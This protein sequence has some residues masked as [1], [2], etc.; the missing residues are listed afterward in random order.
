MRNELEIGIQQCECRSTQD[1]TSGVNTILP[2]CLT[3]AG[4]RPW[5]TNQCNIISEG[6][7]GSLGT[8]ESVARTSTTGTVCVNCILSRDE[9][10]PSFTIQSHTTQTTPRV[11]QNPRRLTLSPPCDDQCQDSICCRDVKCRYGTTLGLQ[12]GDRLL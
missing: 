10:I 11:L 12:A 1:V 6:I 7:D 9:N 3:L 4:L 5:W 2:K 8:L